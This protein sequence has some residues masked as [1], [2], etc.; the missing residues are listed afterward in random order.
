MNNQPTTAP[1]SVL[2]LEDDTGHEEMNGMEEQAT[3]SEIQQPS[4][5][6]ES[7]HQEE[8]LDDLA[9]LVADAQSRFNL[10]RKG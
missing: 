10:S 5:F 1:G 3:E 2:H 7:I 4:D 9:K 6:E 8:D